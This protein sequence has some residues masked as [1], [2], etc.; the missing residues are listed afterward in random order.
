M[1]SQELVFKEGRTF[2]IMK[3]ETKEK[4]GKKIITFMGTHYFD[5]T[6]WQEYEAEIKIEV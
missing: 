5:I 1:I 6:E 3:I 4:V 2:D